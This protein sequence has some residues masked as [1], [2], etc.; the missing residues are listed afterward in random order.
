MARTSGAASAGGLQ[1]A[2]AEFCF[3]HDELFVVPAEALSPQGMSVGFRGLLVARKDVATGWCDRFD[4]AF[5]L[6]WQRS[7]A[8]SQRAPE[9]WLPPL[10]QHVCVVM[11]ASCV[12]PYYQPFEGVSWLVYAGDFDPERSD[13]HP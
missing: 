2:V 5:A 13:Q 3:A 10:R 9:S 4:E 7:L 12:R 6:Y 11:D 1:P 8:L